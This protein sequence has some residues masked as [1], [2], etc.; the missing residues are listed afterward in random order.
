MAETVAQRRERVTRYG[1]VGPVGV[2]ITAGVVY[3]VVHELFH[4]LLGVGITTDIIGSIALGAVAAVG[5]YALDRNLRA[6]TAAF[7]TLFATH[8]LVMGHGGVLLFENFNWSMP[9]AVVAAIVFFLAAGGLG[10]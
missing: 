1:V 7:I 3:F 6:V 10:N 4:A 2:A 9:V 8:Q 5:V